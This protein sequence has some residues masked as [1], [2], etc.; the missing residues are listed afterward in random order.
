METTPSDGGS[1]PGYPPPASWRVIQ[2]LTLV[3][4]TSDDLLEVMN[5]ECPI[6]LEEQKIGATACKLQCGHLYH[7]DCVVKWLNRHCTCK[8]HILLLLSD[9]L[10][11]MF[12][13]IVYDR[14]EGAVI[15]SVKAHHLNQL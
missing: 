11:L 5:K 12:F 9:R 10:F 8:F 4:V 14:H 3:Q 2:K 1:T 7:R 13:L 6:C 15:E